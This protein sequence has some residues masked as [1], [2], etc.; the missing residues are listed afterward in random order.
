[1][2]PGPDHRLLTLSDVE[3]AAQVM[4]QSYVDD[5]LAAF[6]LPFRRTRVR[7]LYKFFRAMG[8]V[9]IKHQRGFGVG[10]PLQGVAY[11]KFPDQEDLSIS[12]RSLGKFL[13]LLFTLYPIGLY[14]A[15]TILKQIDELHKEYAN[16]PHFYLD[17]IG[18]LPVARGRGLS[19]M[20]IRPFLDLADSQ[21]VIAYTDTVTRSNVA[22]YQHLG[23]QCVEE[24]A[25]PGTGITVWALC[26]AIQQP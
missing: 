2:Q 20:L 19:S 6:M 7:T 10:D 25:V 26:R 22:L 18:V 23:F 21:K 1:M 14:R 3:A 17:N 16:E 8:E 24:R 13:P 5:P 9:S 11:W 4:S 15:K 12:V